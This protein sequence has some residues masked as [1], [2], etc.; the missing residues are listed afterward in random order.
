[1]L[2]SG[3]IHSVVFGGFSASALRDRI[4]DAQAKIVIT[5][6]GSLR[7]GRIIPLKEIVTNH[8]KSAVNP[9]KK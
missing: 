2:A 8:W 4:E 9:L 7:G 1:M 3:A 6:N 5:A